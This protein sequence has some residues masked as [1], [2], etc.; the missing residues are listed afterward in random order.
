MRGGCH[1]R[2]VYSLLEVFLLNCCFV[3]QTALL[4]TG[5]F[6]RL[7]DRDRLTTLS[8]VVYVVVSC[9]A[10]FVAVWCVVRRGG[11]V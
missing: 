8:F 11:C 4:V 7:T 3:Q 6:G 1:F 9:C 2:E 10:V 5:N